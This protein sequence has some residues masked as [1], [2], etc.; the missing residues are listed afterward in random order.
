MREVLKSMRKV[1][2]V[3]ARSFKVNAQGQGHAYKQSAL[4]QVETHKEGGINQSVIFKMDF[5]LYE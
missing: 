3:N 1:F 2:K 4:T 5:D